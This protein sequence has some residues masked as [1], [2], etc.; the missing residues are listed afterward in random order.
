MRIKIAKHEAAAVKENHH[1]QLLAWRRM[2]D[3][4]R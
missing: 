4:D 1:R 3:T 2:I